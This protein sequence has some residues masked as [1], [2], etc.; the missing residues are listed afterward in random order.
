MNE[1]FLSQLISFYEE[2]PADPFNLYSLALA[3]KE[4]DAQ[5]SKAYFERLLA[6]HPDYL[7]AYYHAGTLLASLE[8]YEA[9]TETLQAGI[10]LATQQNNP[11]T[12]RELKDAKRAIEDE[13]DLLE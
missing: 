11:K 1:H 2:D 13:L 12:L 4:R 6:E 7:P 3:L 10:L 9:A 5:A 8:E